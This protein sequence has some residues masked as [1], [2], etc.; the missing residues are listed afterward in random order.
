VYN[1]QASCGTLA[2]ATIGGNLPCKRIVF[3]PWNYDENH[4][5]DLKQSVDKFVAPIIRYAL[6]ENF[7][8]IGQYT[9]Y[10]K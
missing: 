3:R 2:F 5:Q 10:A 4:L 6:Q 7:T 9:L 1:Q 8:T